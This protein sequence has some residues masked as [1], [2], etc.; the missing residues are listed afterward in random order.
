MKRMTS[1][2]M[3]L[4]LM[5]AAAPTHAQSARTT[6]DFRWLAGKWEGHLSV[7]ANARA[8]VTFSAP[9]GRSI[10]GMM[11]LVKNDTVLVVELISLVD[12][13]SGVEMRFRHF[14][15][16]L[17]AY[18]PTYKQAMRLTSFDAMQD[19]FENTVPY[20]KTLMSTQPRT[21]KF[22]KQGADGFAGRSDIIGS[23]G[24]PAVIETVYK[25]VR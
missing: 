6:K 13:P 3:A 15:P 8:E 17:E 12:T 4:L 9:N 24:K 19:V 2:L 1:V 7:D 10:V 20:D 18:E 14:S 5:V 25:R 21:T 16:E 11:R 22:I 23:D